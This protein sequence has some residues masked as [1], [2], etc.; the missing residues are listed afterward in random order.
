M[1]WHRL[2]LALLAIH[3]C[4]TDRKYHVAI[5]GSTFDEKRDKFDCSPNTSEDES[6]STIRPSVSE[7]LYEPYF[8]TKVRT[9]LHPSAE[10][11]GKECQTCQHVDQALFE[12]QSNW[13]ELSG[14]LGFLLVASDWR[15]VLT[16]WSRLFAAP[17]ECTH[18]SSATAL[19]TSYFLKGS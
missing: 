6:A 15:G 16:G 8:L 14:M 18:L 13:F 17:V 10:S 7:W 5:E 9:A 1:F 11:S 2:N 12:R 3:I 19:A 4:V